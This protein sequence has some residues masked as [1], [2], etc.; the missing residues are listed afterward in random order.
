MQLHNHKHENKIYQYLHIL[1]NLGLPWVYLCFLPIFLTNTPLKTKVSPAIPP[2][3]VENTSTH[4][5]VD[6]LAC[7]VIFLGFLF[8]CHV[9]LPET[10]IFAPENGSKMS[11]REGSLTSFL[12]F[13]KD[14]HFQLSSWTSNYVSHPLFL[15]PSMLVSR[16]FFSVLQWCSGGADSHWCTPSWFGCSGDEGATAAGLDV[17]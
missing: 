9:T 6:L 4:S 5:L 10:N 16:S 1:I 3:S 11:F 14:I 2:F 15:L 8:F 13:F 17:G 7:H 12:F